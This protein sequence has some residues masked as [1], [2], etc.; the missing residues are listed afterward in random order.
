[1]TTSAL[2]QVYPPDVQDRPAVTVLTSPAQWRHPEVQ[3]AWDQLLEET[4]NRSP[5]TNRQPGSR[6]S[7]RPSPV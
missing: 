5:S 3:A 4:S 6:T 7:A 2:L 1:M